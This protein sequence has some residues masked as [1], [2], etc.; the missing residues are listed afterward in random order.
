MNKITN[1][2]L[3]LVDELCRCEIDRN[4]FISK[5][6]FK[7]D[8]EQLDFLL[9]N[10]KDKVNEYGYHQC[11]LE[12]IWTLP[13]KVSKKEETLINRK[14][15]LENWHNSHE[16]IVQS[17]QLDFNDDVENIPILLQAMKQ[18]P[19]YIEKIDSYPYIRKIIYA[20]G[21]QPEPYNLDAL[22]K[23]VTET[24]DETIKELAL[25]QI[26]KRKQFGRWEYEKNGRK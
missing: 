14:Y 19:K 2:D 18:V 5:T 22:K 15:L 25:H 17:F 4:E 12:L 23:I 6:S 11:F 9:E 8:F 3:Y 7:A 26:D 1:K 13:T 21:A 24:Q 10:S 20:I 16:G